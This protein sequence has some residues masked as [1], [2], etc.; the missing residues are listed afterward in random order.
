LSLSNEVRDVGPEIYFASA[1]MQESQGNIPRADEMYRKALDEAPKNLDILVHYAR[2][3]DRA[4]NLDRAA[5][6]Y[7]QAI[8]A[9]PQE[10]VAYNDLGLCLARQEQYA[11]SVETL[12]RAVQ[13]QQDNPLY[14]NNLAAVLVEVGRPDEALSHLTTAH[15]PAVAHYNLGYLFYKSG[16]PQQA[17]PYL[18]KALALDPQM[19]AARQLLAV[20]SGETPPVAQRAPAPTAIARAVAPRAQQLPRV[21]AN[22]GAWGDAPRPDS[23]P[24][25]LPP[26]N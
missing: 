3:H 19:A 11:E 21:P 24:Q 15:G 22:E 12:G 17:A 14:R 16:K 5:E 1:R 4:G 8:A 2:M 20:M 13:L 25:L 6:I 18:Q 26:V 9:H 10:A 7:R 23:L